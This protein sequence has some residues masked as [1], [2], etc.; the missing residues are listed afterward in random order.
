[1]EVEDGEL[2]MEGD[3]EEDSV[4]CG[5]GEDGSGY[6]RSDEAV[7]IERETDDRVVRHIVDPRLP[8]KEEV[9]AH[10]MLHSPYRN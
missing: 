3:A 10:E 6:G 9:S 1:M 7:K 2:E 4:R 8:T 5:V